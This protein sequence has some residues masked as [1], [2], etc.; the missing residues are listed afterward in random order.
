M[1][2]DWDMEKNWID[3]V[4]TVISRTDWP[5]GGDIYPNGWPSGGIPPF[6]GGF[7]GI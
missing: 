6:A 5:E 4:A 3:G 2:S 1:T 7:D